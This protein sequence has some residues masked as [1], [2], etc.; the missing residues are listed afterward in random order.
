MSKIAEPAVDQPEGHTEGRGRCMRQLLDLARANVAV[1]HEL[2]RVG[3]PDLAEGRRATEAPER[4]SFKS[5]RFWAPSVHARFRG[6]VAV[7]G[8]EGTN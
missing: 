3:S 7:R 4:S 8:H 5:L 1:K 6:T 2:G